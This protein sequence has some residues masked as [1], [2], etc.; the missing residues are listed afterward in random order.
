M[1]DAEAWVTFAAAWLAGRAGDPRVHGEDEKHYAARSTDMAGAVATRMLEI[2][3]LRITQNG[4]PM[5]QAGTPL[6][7]HTQ[8]AVQKMLDEA[9]L[10]QGSASGLPPPL[11]GPSSGQMVQTAG[12]CQRKFPS[13][14]RCFGQ[15]DEQSVCTACRL[16]MLTPAERAA[17]GMGPVPPGVA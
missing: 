1:D 16:P 9:G 8:S 6:S 11:V 4:V 5:R 15:Y 12:A 17:Q 2:K 13:G 7:P 10:G 14:E 3:S